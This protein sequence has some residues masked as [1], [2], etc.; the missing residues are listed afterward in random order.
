[1]CSALVDCYL[2]LFLSRPKM[3]VGAICWKA[4][5]MCSL[6]PLISCPLGM[7]LAISWAS[8]SCLVRGLS[9]VVTTLN[10][11]ASLFFFCDGWCSVKC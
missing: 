2:P 10:E 8:L 3:S 4:G 11:K 9:P 5:A 6:R 7:S 1:M